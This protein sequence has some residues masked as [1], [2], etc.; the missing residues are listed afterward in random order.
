MESKVFIKIISFSF[1]DYDP[2]TKEPIIVPSISLDNSNPLESLIDPD[3][4]IFNHDKYKILIDYPVDE[5]KIFELEKPSENGTT[6]IE[7]LKQI[8]KIYF[9]LFKHEFNSE[10]D[11]M[12]LFVLTHLQISQ[13]ENGEILLEL[14]IDT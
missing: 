7:L 13:L 5:E 6:R 1:K 12:L 8:R 10:E 4:L 11:F 9:D 14:G 2:E 3:D